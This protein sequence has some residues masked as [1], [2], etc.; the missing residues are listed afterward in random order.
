M[1]IFKNRYQAEKVRKKGEE[2]VVRVCGGY[3]IMTYFDY[4]VWR[5]Q[6]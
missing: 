1:E 4:Q 5:T 2:V 6:K 3:A